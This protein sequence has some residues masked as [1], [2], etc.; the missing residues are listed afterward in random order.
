MNPDEQE[1]EVAME[2]FL[3]HALKTGDGIPDTL[4]A[5]LGRL[6]SAVL[7]MPALQIVSRY[8]SSPMTRMQFFPI[9]I[10]YSTLYY[11]ICQQVILL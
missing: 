2:A 11:E 3:V 7:P 8:W 5:K 6:L 4:L 10:A 1:V 9:V